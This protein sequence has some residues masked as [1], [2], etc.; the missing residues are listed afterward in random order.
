[1][2]KTTVELPDSLLREA[3][4]VAL[5]ERTT[6]RA[7][8]ER[9][10]RGVLTSRRPPQ[11]FVLRDGDVIT[12]PK[13]QTLYI[14][15]EVRTNS[16]LVWRRNLTLIQA[17]TLAGGLTERGTLRGATATRIVK[18]KT[19]EVKLKDQDKVLPDDV[20]TIHRKLF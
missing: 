16:Q 9:G 4:R 15:G 10:L 6:V 8:I 20:I 17:V 1:M 11:A 19:I 13:A 12:V 3:K 14:G 5:R 18:D 7:L 2:K